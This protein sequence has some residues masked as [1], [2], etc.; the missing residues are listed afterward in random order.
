MDTNIENLVKLQAVELERSRLMQLAKALPAEI[1][2]AESALAAM[3]A[4]TAAAADA[5]NREDSLR[6]KLDREITG[7]R[8]KAERYKAQ[9]D[10]V[11]TPAQASAIE[12]EVQFAQA[13]IDRLETEEFAS[14]ERSEVQ[15]TT[16]ATARAQVEELAGTLDKTKE[17]VAA[18]QRELTQQQ[19]TLGA[20]REA[21]R[22]EIAP[23]LLSRFDR[24]ATSRGTGI[25]RVDNQQCIGCR[26]GVRPQM[27]NQLREGELLTCDSC[28]RLLYWDP[29]MAPAPKT[30][31]PDPAVAD[32][33]HAIRKPRQAGA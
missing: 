6:T 5:L 29:A 10:S 32:T 8:Q 1:H 26:M 25:A 11:T 9:Q 27:W 23:E 20:E 28:G 3:Q 17:R 30:P 14:L 21:L 4:K 2:Q 12:H 15:E 33:G 13:E 7:H 24:I 31:Q 22:K 19:T 16:L 18:S